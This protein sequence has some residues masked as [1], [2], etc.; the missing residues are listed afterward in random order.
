MQISLNK[1]A[2]L[3]LGTELIRLAHNYKGGKHYHIDPIEN[4]DASQVMGIILHPESCELI[5]C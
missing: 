3:R 2:L 5:I 4:E 1:N